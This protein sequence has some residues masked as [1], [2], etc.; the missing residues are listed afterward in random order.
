MLGAA[1]PSYDSSGTW[2]GGGVFASTVD[3]N[4]TENGGTVITPNGH[5]NGTVGIPPPTM[6]VSPASP[7]SRS[8]S[9]VA[10]VVASPVH[11]DINP[12]FGESRNSVGAT[13]KPTAYWEHAA[14]APT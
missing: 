10:S 5:A 2:L 3:H 6:G 14:E 4:G 7:S 1:A 8:A 11:V 13:V 12:E 9:P